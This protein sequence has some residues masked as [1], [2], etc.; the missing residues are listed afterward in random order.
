M[1]TEKQS[2]FS[3]EQ[4]PTMFGIPRLPPPRPPR[5]GPYND[6]FNYDFAVETDVT[7]GRRD[8]VRDRLTRFKVSALLGDLGISI[9]TK[10][11]DRTLGSFGE[12]V[13]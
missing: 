10:V 7:A 4:M 6:R 8:A 2:A 13:L 12:K 5:E 11:V 9:N 3:G 1:G